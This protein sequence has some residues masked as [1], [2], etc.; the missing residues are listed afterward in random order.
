VRVLITG[1]RGQVGSEI[2]ALLDHHEHLCTDHAELDLG[3]RD[4]IEQVVGSYAPDVV[5]NCGA[6][7]DVDGAESRPDDAMRINGLAVRWLAIAAGR[8]GAHMVHV[9][10]DYVFD[11]TKDGPYDE[12]DPPAPVS[13]YGRTKLAGELELARHAPSATLVRTAWVFGRRG[14]NFV[15]TILDRAI[16]GQPLR[17][18]DDQ[19]GSPTYAPDLAAVLVRLGTA[20]RS[21]LFHV[22]NQDTCTWHDLACAAIEEAG[23]DASGVAR[24]P[25]SELGRP[26]PRPA[27]SVLD[28]AALRLG[29]EALCRPWRA[30]LAERVAARMAT[31]Q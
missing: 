19:R 3:D 23:L 6:F 1:G 30:A 18:V 17:V 24:M 2:P 5:I 7:T 14:R 16:D 15:D 10:T 4:R 22:T 12:W 31:A 9:S 13:V 29:G 25:S 28:N 21:G 20:R 11:G 27:N 26:A 8:V